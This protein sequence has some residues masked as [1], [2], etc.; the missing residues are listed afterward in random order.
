MR[1][2]Y[3]SRKLSRKLTF[4]EDDGQAYLGVTSLCLSPTN[5]RMSPRLSQHGYILPAFASLTLAS[6]VIKLPE[7][8]LV[9]ALDLSHLVCMSLLVLTS[10]GLDL[11]KLTDTKF[12]VSLNSGQPHLSNCQPAKM[13]SNESTSTPATTRASTD[14]SLFHSLRR[15][16]VSPL[17]RE[18]LIL[19]W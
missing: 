8:A 7:Q 15:R 1:G 12:T 4:T 11:T 2:T 16:S 19:Q 5:L 13:S 6:F 10:S 18:A 17:P 14:T 9:S 3:T